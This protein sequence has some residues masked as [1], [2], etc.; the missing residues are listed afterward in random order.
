MDSEPPLS[1]Q[2]AVLSFVWDIGKVLGGLL[3]KEGKQF[4]TSTSPFCVPSRRCFTL[5]Y[6]SLQRGFFVQGSGLA[7]KDVVFDK[8]EPP[9]RDLTHFSSTP[10]WILNKTSIGSRIWQRR[11]FNLKTCKNEPCGVQDTLPPTWDSLSNED[12]DWN[13]ALLM[14]SVREEHFYAQFP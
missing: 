2:V 12:V 1:N 11:S 8:K 5:A 10:T 6:S 13:M 3:D 7:D 14:Q 9:L 4:A